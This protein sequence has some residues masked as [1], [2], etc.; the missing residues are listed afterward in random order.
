[1]STFPELILDQSCLPSCNHLIPERIQVIESKIILGKG[2]PKIKVDITLPGLSFISRKHAEIDLTDS[3]CVI[4]DLNSC[5]GT[6]VNNVRIDSTKLQDGDIVQ[7]GGSKNTCIGETL[8]NSDIACLKYIFRSGK[9]RKNNQNMV[10]KESKKR[11]VDSD[12]ESWHSDSVPQLNRSTTGI[13]NKIV[14]NSNSNLS[15]INN[16]IPARDNEIFALQEELTQLKKS[17]NNMK[18]QLKMQNET[19]AEP[20]T[21]I[22]MLTTNNNRLNSII[23]EQKTHE[24]ELNKLLLTI[25]KDIQTQKICTEKFSNETVAMN[26]LSHTVNN[27][28]SSSGSKHNTIQQTI[29]TLNI[30]IQH[31]YNEYNRRITEMQVQI[32]SQADTIELLGQ[33]KEEL[34]RKH[35]EHT[36]QLQL[37]VKQLQEEVRKIDRKN[38]ILSSNTGSSNTKERASIPTTT[39]T[40]SSITDIA[41]ENLRNN[42]QCTLCEKLLI[43]AV[44]LP[45]SHGFCRACIETHWHPSSG[46]NSNN[47]RNNYSS[48]TSS[49]GRSSCSACRCPTC[50]ISAT[51]PLTVYTR[52]ARTQSREGYYIHSDHLDNLIWFVREGSAPALHQVCGVFFPLYLSW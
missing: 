38:N 37:Q 26:T 30:N 40:T 43:D 39:T 49:S 10:N 16:I 22:Q 35:N 13:Q 6:F 45:C 44:V 24:K 1:M 19:V 14:S 50:N 25:V 29:N 32:S 15:D 4:T 28:S 21:R 12:D 7:F 36:T 5:N 23:N 11:K 20:L 2:A 47:T 33:E 27:N 9:R 34:Y 31:L 48:S 41:N 42:L 8:I 46:F 17:Y 51:S 3:D 18:T 52:Q